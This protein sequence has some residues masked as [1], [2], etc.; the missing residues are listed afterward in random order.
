[1]LAKYKLYKKKLPLI[2]YMLTKGTLC[3]LGDALC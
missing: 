2:T 3:V 1:M